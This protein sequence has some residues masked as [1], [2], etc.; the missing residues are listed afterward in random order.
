MPSWFCLNDLTREWPSVTIMLF[1]LSRKNWKSNQV[2]FPEKCIFHI[3]KSFLLSVQS[4][5]DS[6]FTGHLFQEIELQ[7]SQEYQEDETSIGSQMKKQGKRRPIR[8][9]PAN[10]GTEIRPKYTANYSFS[11]P[12]T[13]QLQ[14]LTG[15]FE[16]CWLPMPLHAEHLD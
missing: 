6:F 8:G 15:S 13:R 5:K 9:K 2:L 3:V 1:T 12:R 16:S 10:S 14:V 11:K 4:S 7:N